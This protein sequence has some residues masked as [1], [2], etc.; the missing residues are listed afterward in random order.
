MKKCPKCGTEHK[1]SGVYCSRSCANSRKFSSEAR[2]KKSIA[3]IKYW[4]S[5]SDEDKK[6]KIE[7]LAQARKENIEKNLER[8]LTQDWD[9]LGLQSKRLRVIIEQDGKCNRCG[10]S[11]WMGEKITLE[12]EHKDGNKYNNAR[13]NVE[14]LCPN[15]HSQTK[16][17]RGRKNKNKQ[18]RVEKYISI[19]SD[20]K[21]Y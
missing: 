8:L 6:K 3:S 15:C 7:I 17:W 18:K 13:E 14:A 10:I 1:K 19:I 20:K 9:V 5:L 21:R 2:K 12:Y 11:E 16:T 4:E